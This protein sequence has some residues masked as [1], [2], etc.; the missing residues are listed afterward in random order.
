MSVKLSTDST[1]NLIIT[2][3]ADNSTSYEFNL[4]LDTTK[5]NA[6]D[7]V[8]TTEFASGGNCNNGPLSFCYCNNINCYNCNTIQCTT[9]ECNTVQCNT[10]QC[11]TVQCN[12]V[13]CTTVQCNGH[14]NSNCQ[15]CH[16]CNNCSGDC[17]QCKSGDRNT[18]NCECDTYTLCYNCYNCYDCLNT[19]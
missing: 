19:N 6:L 1:P 4:Q 18:A 7:P 2:N 3:S 14:C 10:I 8:T 17:Y 16:D 11:T 5:V 13:Q 9:V 12:T 15:Q